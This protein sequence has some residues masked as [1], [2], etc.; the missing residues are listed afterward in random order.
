MLEQLLEF[1][2]N[3]MLA[4]N[5]CHN[6]F[7]DILMPFVTHRYTGIPIYLGIAFLIFYKRNVKAA[8]IIFGA[9]VV[10]FAL[11]DSLSVAL[12]KETVQRLRP[13]WNPETE[14]LVRMLEGKGGQYGFVSSHAANLFGLAVITSLLLNKRWYTVF[15]FSWAV[16]IGYSRIYVGKHYPLD[17]ICGALFGALI[18]FIIYKITL[19]ICKKTKINVIHH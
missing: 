15:I 13:C 11:C 9:V 19:Y 16:V 10:T 6:G 14:H 18:G 1:D 7:L 2:K 3:L 5:G 12:F 4:I 17:I 8:L